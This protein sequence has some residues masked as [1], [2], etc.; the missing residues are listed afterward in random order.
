MN[1]SSNDLSGTVSG[2][3]VQAGHVGQLHITPAAPA[4]PAAPTALAGLPPDVPEFTGRGTA[5]DAVTA[6]LRPDSAASP[7]VVSTLAGT[8]GIGKTALAVRAAHDAVA[9]GW[10]PGG[11]LFINL[12]GYDVDRAVRPD[13]ALSVFL[14][15]LGV[16][17]EL[18]P[19]TFQGRLS[20]YRS[21]LAEIASRHGAV[22]VFLDNAS[23]TEQIGPLLPAAP[24]HRVLVTSRH[25]LGDLPGSR[26][27]DVGVL[28]PAEAAALISRTLRTRRPGDTR[29]QDEPDA[30]RDLAALCGHLPLALAVVA[31]ILAGDPD[32]SVGELTA[33]LRDRATRL[34]E[35]T[36]GQRRSV[37][38]AFELSYARLTAEEAR[39][40][41]LLSLN[42]GQQV[43]L[44]AA[45]ALTGGS[46]PRARKQLRALRDAHMIE[47]GEPHGWVRF[48]DLLRLFAEWRRQEEDDEASVERAVDGLLVHYRD[49]ARDAVERLVAEA[50]AGGRDEAAEEWL[51]TERLNLRSALHLAQLHG[52]SAVVLPLAHHVS[53]L[54]RRQQDWSAGLEVCDMAVR[55]ARADT[56]QGQLA[57]A[58]YNKGDFLKHKQDYGRALPVFAEAL[59]GY[60]RLGD[61]A[62]EAR[63]L[64]SMGTVARRDRQYAEAERYYSAAL[65]LFR[66][67]DDQ[68]ATAHTLFNLGHTARGQGDQELAEDCYRQGLDAYQEAGH[69]IG[70][71]RTLHRLGLLA[72]ATDR[73]ELARRHWEQART[74]YEAAGHAECCGRKVAALLDG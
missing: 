2:P 67:L 24:T 46:V 5:L 51:D 55:F 18:F 19:P 35:L 60:R 66:A 20:L 39:M 11:V 53:W 29:A 72:A 47:P 61:R 26:I 10:F 37:A 4:A 69:L 21:K 59:D 16:P 43:S 50:R 65:P 57:L 15:A 40:F 44:A 25:T 30:V 8:A 1:Q 64:H 58:L 62:G 38:A 33:A 23:S 71:A 14:S 70:R 28:E 17:D 13:I 34:E 49:S 45:A 74:A 3:V 42:L 52:R 31:S 7:L 22:L 63:T 41:R 12:Q 54:L 9:A 32:Q 48:H 68:Q 36:Y 73:P 56:D 27:V 6:G